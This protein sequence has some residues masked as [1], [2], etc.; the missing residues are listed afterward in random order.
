MAQHI[1]QDISVNMGR[2]R[3]GC[4]K[5]LGILF[6]VFCL[7]VGLGIFLTV[8]WVHKQVELYTAESPVTLPRS[9]L[10]DAQYPAV[11]DRVTKFIQALNNGTPTE[12]LVLNEQELNSYLERAQGKEVG[13]HVYLNL[14]GS[15][16]KGKVS[17]PLD[18]L[19][20]SW[21]K[22]RYLNG[23]VTLNVSLQ[24]GHLM[25]FA[26]QVEVNGMQAP[27]SVMQ[28]MRVKNLAEKAT[29][30]PKNAATI[31]KI[32]SLQVKDGK[33]IMEAQGSGA[34]N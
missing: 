24:N 14:D 5:I 15:M 32:K 13:D 7:I 20:W 2:R 21:V 33:L 9:T 30:D 1:N 31:A 25:V 11:L 12:P 3:G 8:H 27:D 17:Y 26:E 10:P 6:L 23:N 34:T 29:Q 28:G 22:G 19:N 18:S 4:L 16:V